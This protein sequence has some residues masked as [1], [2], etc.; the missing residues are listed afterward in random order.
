MSQSEYPKQNI[1]VADFESGFLSCFERP[2]G[3]KSEWPTQQVTYLKEYLKC[4]GCTTIVIEEHYIDRDYIRDDALFYAR[5]LRSYPNHCKRLHFFT[6]KFDQSS[7]RERLRRATGA[8]RVEVEKEFQGSYLGFLV[9]RPLAGVPVGRTVIKTFPIDSENGHKRNFKPTRCYQV[10]LALFSLKVTGLAFQEQDQ[11]VSACATTALWTALHSVAALEN[12][13]LPAPAQITEAAA[14]HQSGNRC[15]PSQ[16]LTI[17]Q[18]CEATRAFGLDP[19]VLPLRG[20]QG[21]KSELIGYINSGFPVILALI[22]GNGVGHAVCAVGLKLGAARVDDKFGFADHASRV[23]AV[24]IHDDRLGPYACAEISEEKDASSGK[25][26]TSLSIHWPDKRQNDRAR[27]HAIIV[28]VPVK[29]RLTIERMRIIGSSVAKLF[30]NFGS[31]NCELTYGYRSAAKF[32]QDAASFGLSHDGLQQL[33]CNTTL[34]RYIGIVGIRR[35]DDVP[36][37][38]IILDTTETDVNPMVLVVV[39]HPGSTDLE[40][41]VMVAMAEEIFN[42]PYVV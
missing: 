6:E 32:V 3:I 14:R 13:A 17:Q 37:V 30:P 39:I 23:T 2:S 19:L 29:I 42:A 7:W 38:D 10:H 4:L 22:M 41:K 8:A 16:G 24:Y 15:L 5:S 18:I 40:K 36:V 28:P 12:L 20:L 26:V 21:D 9:K 34:S 1:H 35:L 33:A 11:G 31:H 27:L 25:K